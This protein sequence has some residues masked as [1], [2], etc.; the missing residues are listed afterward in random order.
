MSLS[1]GTLTF[2]PEAVLSLDTIPEK[3]ADGYII[4][5]ADEIV[6]TPLLSS[7]PSEKWKC[8]RE[9]SQEGREILRLVYQGKGLVIFVR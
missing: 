6:G 8:I 5:V 2:A 3:N 4:A 9:T 7:T 1:G